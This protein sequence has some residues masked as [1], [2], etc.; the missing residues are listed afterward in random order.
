MGPGR[1]VSIPSGAA[2]SKQTSRCLRTGRKRE[3]DGIRYYSGTAVY[4]KTFAFTPSADKPRVVLDL[5]RVEVMAEVK[6]NGKDLGTLWKPPYRV[7]VTH[8]IQPGENT[9]E[10]KVVNLL[11]QPHDRRRAIAR[12]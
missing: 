8:A 5:G 12:G 4:R 6:L 7:D 11:D 10:V 1:L 3:E 9:L 2:P